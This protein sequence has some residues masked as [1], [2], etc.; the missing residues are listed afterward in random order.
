MRCVKT[1]RD[2]VDLL[3][4]PSKTAAA[5]G[6]S[7]QAVIFW[8]DGRRELPM[9]HG[10]AIELATGGQVRRWHLWPTEWARIWPELIGTTGA[11]EAPAALE[12]TRNAA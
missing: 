10:A 9:R 5:I 6:V 7:P 2:A 11:P 4:G 12:G 8:R 3:G 1:F